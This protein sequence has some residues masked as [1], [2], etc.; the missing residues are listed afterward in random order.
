MEQGKNYIVG[1]DLGIKYAQIS[2]ATL[3]GEEGDIYNIPVCL[4][5]R[6]NANQWFY[7]EEARK[8]AA[9]F[10]GG[11]VEDL[12]SAAVEGK[13]IPVES[14]EADPTELLS[15]FVR[16]CLSDLGLYKNDV[17][18]QAL[19]ISVD[20]FTERT[21]QVLSC[22]KEKVLSSFEQVFFEPKSECLFSY[23]IHQPR[24]MRCYEIG[25]IDL[26]E[27]FLK[28]Y[29]IQ[30]N[31]K[32]KPVLT[33]IDEMTDPDYVIREDFSSVKEKE[34]FL[35]EMDERLAKVM[36]EFLNNRLVTVFYLTG[37]LFDKEWCP[38]TIKIICKNR[39]VFGGSNLY[40][41]G[42]CLLGMEK[43]KP[44][45]EPKEYLYLGKEKLKADIGIV[46]ASE[47]SPVKKR[48][49]EGGVNWFEV[50]EEFLFM[51]DEDG[52]LPIVISPL[53]EKKERIVPV[54]LPAMPDRDIKSIRFQCQLTMKSVDELVVE[55]ED[56]GFG[57][58]YKPTGKRYREIIS[59]RF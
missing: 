20:S 40:S 3:E 51:P 56:T 5:K 46:M 28:F 10:K 54:I 58:F 41:R 16:N 52:K 13:P 34:S 17:F 47:G 44:D 59:L 26:S 15:L 9:N 29:H 14:E 36:E 21:L 48:V 49:I 6:K 23:I 30:M 7:G 27:N 22:V 8:A 45:S 31:G 57:E 50:K 25:V 53:G 35:C 38:K 2:Y 18:V 19:V 32:T 42:A 12:L 1:L 37:K 55:V 39:R 11:L 4:C 43:I 24:E 33:T